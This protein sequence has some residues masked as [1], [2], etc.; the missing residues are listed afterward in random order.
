MRMSERRVARRNRGHPQHALLVGRQ[1]EVQPQKRT[2]RGLRRRHLVPARARC[3]LDVAE[4]VRAETRAACLGRGNSF[5]ARRGLTC[6]RGGADI[7][8]ETMSCNSPAGALAIGIITRHV[9][10]LLMILF[11]LLLICLLLFLIPLLLLLLLFILLLLLL[12]RPPF[13]TTTSTRHTT[14]RTEHL[15]PSTKH[16]T[17][18]S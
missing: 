18:N 8:G 2:A 16:P 15:N 7:H 3:F 10:H 6:R 9:Q 4:H 12:I 11:K 5:L 1:V 14:A 17:P 13:P